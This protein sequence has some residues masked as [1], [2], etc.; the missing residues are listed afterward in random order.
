MGLDS[1]EG[2][3]QDRMIKYRFPG[4]SIALLKEGEVVHA[5]GLGFRDLTTSLPATPSTNYHVGS[6][7][8]AFT[9]AAIMQLVE[10]G[11]V[12]L[13]DPVNKYVSVVKSDEIRVHHLL[14]HTSGIPALGYAEALIDSYYGLGSEWL[15]TAK[16]DDV[17]T[18]M[19]GYQDWFNHKP[20]ERWFYLNEGYVILGKIIEKVSGQSY[21]S[22]VKLNV[23]ERLGMMK[24]YFT[25]DEYVR[26]E[27]KATPY[28]VDKEGKHA[29]VE[30]LFGVSADGGLFSNVL[31][32]LK[33][34]S[35]L[36][37][38]GSYMGVEILSK[39]SVELMEKPHVRL[40]YDSYVADSYGLGLT[41]RSNFLGR[42]LI[43]HGGSVL[44]H[45][46]Y[47]GYV[48]ESRVGVAVLANMSGYPLSLIGAYALT[49]V[50]G[51]DPAKELPYVAVERVYDKLVGSYKGYKGTIRLRVRRLGGILAIE[52]EGA[53]TSELTPLVPDGVAEDHALFMV[54]TLAGRVPVEFFIEDSGRVRMTYERYELIR[55]GD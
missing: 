55:A 31:D 37:D 18:F 24:S 29:R 12:S 51:M 21:E 43:G 35:M 15:P 25:R 20:G 4:V 54:Y 47:I 39:E 40:P 13:E 28:I 16:P 42:R 26:D 11:L 2:F 23:L 10:R 53:R 48:P 5:R 14:T 44:V 49:C 46:A 9:S 38:R 30:P 19:A 50:M 3:I 45:T 1:L 22:Y 8:K 7:T 34:V 41:I 33:F 36:I 6:V 52:N 17:L 27:D 32:L